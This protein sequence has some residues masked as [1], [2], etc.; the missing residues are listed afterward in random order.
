MEERYGLERNIDQRQQEN[1]EL[2]KEQFFI[3]GSKLYKYT[4]NNALPV[5]RKLYEECLALEARRD[6]IDGK[7]RNLTSFSLEYQDKL[8]LSEKYSLKKDSLEAAARSLKIRLG[9]IL[10]ERVSMLLAS[11][12]DF[13]YV[14][15]DYGKELELKKRGESRNPI[16]KLASQTGLQR[17]QKSAN[18]RYIAYIDRSIRENKLDAIGGNNAPQIISELN[19]LTNQLSEC[20]SFIDDNEAFIQSNSDNISLL[21]KNGLDS[22]KNMLMEANAAFKDSIS[23]YGCYLFDKGAIW[24]S[25]TT[26]SDILDSIEAILALQGECAKIDRER[27]RIARDDKVQQFKALIRNEEEKIALLRREREKIDLEIDNI[28]Q[29]I[30]RMKAIIERML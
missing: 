18:D 12:E 25:E 1:L 5:G 10:Y 16:D 4:K 28:Q 6:E 21:A 17:F 20:N 29:E 15:E 26:P 30:D 14:Y 24:V 8:G 7:Y 27:E 19:D 9:A 22:Y 2:I 23:N 13:P 11:K 3:L